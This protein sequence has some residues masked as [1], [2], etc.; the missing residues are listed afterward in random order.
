M[1]CI[2]DLDRIYE[3]PIEELI[4]YK[5]DENFDRTEFG[6]DPIGKKIAGFGTKNGGILLVGQRDFR[7][8]G[9]VFGINKEFHKEFSEAIKNV[10][11][12]P[13]TKSK[14][15]KYKNIELALIQ[16]KDV[17]ELRPCAYKKTFYERKS[18][19]IITLPPE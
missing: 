1:E 4:K 5:E 19:S 18:D 11:P 15:V 7:S 14:I 13:L 6:Q 17:G 8:G 16:I 12:T 9:D 2:S 10:K 3:L